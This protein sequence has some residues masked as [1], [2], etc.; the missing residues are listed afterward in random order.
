MNQQ[1]SRDEADRLRVLNRYQVL[2]TPAE[3]RFDA[4]VKLTASVFDVPSAI[5]VM[6][7]TPPP[8]LVHVTSQTLMVPP[9]VRVPKTRAFGA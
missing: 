6:C 5:P 4:I 9:G 2:D 7:C 1:L 3:D 8:A